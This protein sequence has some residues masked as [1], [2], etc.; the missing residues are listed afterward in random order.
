M[1]LFCVNTSWS[2]GW[3]I[4]YINT[5]SLNYKNLQNISIA[6]YLLAEI[7]WKHLIQELMLE[8]RCGWYLSGQFIQHLCAN[9]TDFWLEIDGFSEISDA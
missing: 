4:I 5:D 9:T 3:G 2:S 1:I 6:Q 8:C 7:V